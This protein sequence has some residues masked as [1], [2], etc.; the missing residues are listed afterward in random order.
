MNVRLTP[1]GRAVRDAAEL[2]DPGRVDALLRLLPPDRRQRAVDGL[3]ILA[4]AADR[5]AALGSEHLDALV[6][7][8]HTPDDPT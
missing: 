2:V 7:S 1:E 6:S 4:D 3:A 5:L 8:R